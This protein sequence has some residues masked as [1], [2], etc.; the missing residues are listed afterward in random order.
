MDA[1]R[2]LDG[3]R[4]IVV[5]GGGAGNGRGI[6]RGVAAAGG[7]VVVVDIDPGRANESAEEINAAGG[8]AHALTG[9][10]RSRIRGRPPDV[11]CGR[12]ARRAGLARHRRGRLLAV[13]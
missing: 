8:K 6:A 9:D 13:R 7:R 12:L 10:V 1:G 5:G 2:L 3:R 11:R 4:V